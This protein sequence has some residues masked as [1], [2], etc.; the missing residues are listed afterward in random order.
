MYALTASNITITTYINIV[1][2][3]VPTSTWTKDGVP[4][5]LE[6]R[7]NSYTVGV[8]IISSVKLEDDGHYNSTLVNN[9]STISNIIELKVVGECVEYYIH[10]Y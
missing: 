7:F 10:F 5:S 4:L 2:N 6:G 1:G 8:L 9:M 3:P